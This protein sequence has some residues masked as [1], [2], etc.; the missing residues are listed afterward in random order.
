MTKGEA[1]LFT[2]AGPVKIKHLEQKVKVTPSVKKICDHCK[3]VR[4]HR[5]VY[6]ICKNPKHKMRQG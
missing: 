3:I 4:R 1:G 2:E 6:L 5:R